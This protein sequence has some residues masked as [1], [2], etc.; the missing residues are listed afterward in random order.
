[1]QKLKFKMAIRS[2][3]SQL[4]IS[5]VENGSF[6]IKV[7]TGFSVA[8]KS[9]QRSCFISQIRT[10]AIV[11]LVL[12]LFSRSHLLSRINDSP[13]LTKHIAYCS[14]NEVLWFHFFSVLCCLYSFPLNHSAIKSY[15]LRHMYSL[16]VSFSLVWHTMIRP[17][18]HLDIG[19]SL[20]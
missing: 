17:I 10:I 20:N 9:Q 8:F 19:I 12:T 5:R 6:Y 7:H 13:E 18:A 15:D 16:N 4:V 3:E 11:S 1:M 14:L 2:S